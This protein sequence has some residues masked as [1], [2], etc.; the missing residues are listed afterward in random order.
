MKK[1]KTK[2]TGKQILSLI[3]SVL[4]IFSAVFLIFSCAKNDD[5]SNSSNNNNNN[6]E[7][8][9]DNANNAGED[10]NNPEGVN[11][12]EPAEL[13]SPIPEGVQ[14]G[15]EE[16]RIL[17]CS[18]FGEELVFMNAEGEIGEIVN[19]GVYRRNIKVQSD[20]NVNFKF[21]DIS[22]QNAGN[23]QKMVKNS[24]NAGSDDYDFLI[25][26]QYDC[27][28]LATANVYANLAGAP[29]ID[30]DKPWWPAKNIQEELVIGKNTLYFLGGDI[31]LNFIRNMGCVFFNKQLYSE[32]FDNHPDEMYKLVLDGKW[33]I[34][35]LDEMSKI[36]YKDLN[37]DG[38]F[39]DG[40]QYGSGVIT[41][42]LTDHFTY[43]AGVR[44]TERDAQGVPYFVMNNERTV[45]FTEKLHNLFYNNEGVRVYVSAEETNNALIPGKFKNN[46]LLFDFGWFYISELLRDMKTD[47]GVI[48]YPK[49]DENQPSYLSLAHDIVPLYCVPTTC[50]KTEAVCAVL[51]SMAFESYKSLVP[52]YY[53]IALKLKY[54]RD[55]N[56]DAFKIIDMIHDNCTTDFAYVYNYALNSVGLIM[57]ELMAG[58]SSDFVS[59]YEKIE[60][61]AQK[62]LE[63]LIDTYLNNGD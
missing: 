7:Q 36:M 21:T 46:E 31:S 19:D 38:K 1:I 24:V 12:E 32:N 27:V 15:G 33:T 62:S 39:D 6:K 5:S 40:D 63:K 30:L 44:A 47:Y 54:T 4:L 43:A 10:N 59:K 50:V 22:L 20:L 53:E 45:S 25:G 52:A 60:P 48:P 14:F 18:Y 35:K 13:I 49:F 34:D 11:A 61:K 51:E 56:E 57:R 55:T 58:K 8:N 16:I 37:G 2:K 17:N 42:N 3:L 26:V 9:N 28:Q 23:F 41:N 29:Y